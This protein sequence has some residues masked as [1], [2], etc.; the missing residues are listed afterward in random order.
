[1]PV[2]ESHGDRV[3]ATDDDEASDSIAVTV[4]VGDMHPDCP[5]TDD[6]GLTND[7][8]ALL[9]A[10]ADLGGDLDWDAGTA[11]ADWEG[12]TMS[13]DDRVSE[14]WLKGTKAWTARYPQRSVAW[15]C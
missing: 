10:K 3:T 15:K 11:V 6:N 12:V 7:C 2:G 14:V 8:E 9:D 5:A 1:M 13:D 4:T